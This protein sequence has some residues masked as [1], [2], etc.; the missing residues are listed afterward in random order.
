MTSPH[1]TAAETGDTAGKAEERSNLYGF[2]AMI[3]RQEPSAD[4]L[5]Q[6]RG[7]EFLA[8]LSDAGVTLGRAFLDGAA[9][10]L[11]DDLAVEY[12]RLF[13]GPGKHIPP[14]ESVQRE[15][16]LWGGTTR[17]VAAFVER[18]GF[19]YDPGYRG[20]PDHISVELEFMHELTRREAAAWTRGD[21][22]EARR[23]LRIE[24]EFLHDH[25]VRWAPEFSDKVVAETRTPF[26]KE[27]AALTGDFI[28]RDDE[29]VARRIGNGVDRD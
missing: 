2:L 14:Y 22:A 28:R 23:C 13:V 26:Y 16:T 6:F 10:A 19:A 25:L 9:D 17:D 12:T 15:G 11:A 7:E 8:A 29:D 20:L 21:E 18:C 5:Q 3:H 1:S 4:L 27:L 24:R